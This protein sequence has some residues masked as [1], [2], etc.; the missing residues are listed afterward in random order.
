MTSPKTNQGFKRD[1]EIGGWSYEK[2][3]FDIWPYMTHKNS[4]I[5]GHWSNQKFGWLV[6]KL[7]LPSEYCGF[8]DDMPALFQHFPFM[9]NLQHQHGV[10]PMTGSTNMESKPNNAPT[11]WGS[12]KPFKVVFKTLGCGSKTLVHW[13]S[14]IS[15]KPIVSCWFLL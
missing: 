10:N 8:P 13:S 3:G 15:S 12:T 7:K 5:F 11:N 9:R 14:T 1:L 2:W 6:W 4:Q